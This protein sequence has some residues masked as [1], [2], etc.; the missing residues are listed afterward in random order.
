[1]ET[2]LAAPGRLFSRISVNKTLTKERALMLCLAI[3]LFTMVLEFVASVFTGSL[4]LF[5][6]GIHML[7]HAASLFISWLALYFASRYNSKKYPFGARRLEILAAFVNGLSLL[8]FVGYIM[9][10]AFV[11]LMDPQAIQVGATLSIAIIGLAVNLITAFILSLAGLEDLNT[12][13]AFMHM[14]ADTFSSVAIIVGAIVI[15]YTGWLA[16]DGLLSLVVALVIAKWSFGLLRD[17]GRILLERTPDTVDV[18]AIAKDLYGRYD[19]IISVEEVKAWEIANNEMAANLRLKVYPAE[20]YEYK[21][22]KREI[23]Q[24]L[25]KKFNVVHLS[26]EIDW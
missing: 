13:S 6:D 22:M 10:E 9:F 24:R 26:V 21:R 18:D 8:F 2:L 16:L 19:T 15:S 7:S 11:R 4:M 12:R 1:M 3:T 25:L 17:S 23:R 14:L 20:S 5:S